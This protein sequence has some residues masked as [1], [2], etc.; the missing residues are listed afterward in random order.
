MTMQSTT[1]EELNLEKIRSGQKFVAYTILI[2]II[3]LVMLFSARPNSNIMALFT[4]F[5][6]LV[7]LLFGVTGLLRLCIGLGHDTFSGIL[8]VI[9]FYVISILG[10][11]ILFFLNARATKI[12]K[13][14][15][16]K[17]GLLGAKR[18][19]IELSPS[20]NPASQDARG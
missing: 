19:K 16:F 17:V 8:L 4:L 9:A 13:S 14:E 3:Y 7:N 11:P 10:L 6:L 18:K 12:L 5:A 1:P 20:G 2:N 15:G